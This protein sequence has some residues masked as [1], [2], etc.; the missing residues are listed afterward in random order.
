MC[1]SRQRKWQLKMADQGRCQN[2]GKE[3]E[4]IEFTLCV[5]CA[6]KVRDKYSKKV[7]LKKESNS[8]RYPVNV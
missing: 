1:L 5:S 6:K 2:C 7:Y 8:G 3:K 4:N